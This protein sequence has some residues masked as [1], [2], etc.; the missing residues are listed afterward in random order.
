[1]I[2]RTRKFIWQGILL[3]HTADPDDYGLDFDNELDFHTRIKL[4]KDLGYNF[5][6]EEVEGHSINIVGRPLTMPGAHCLKLNAKYIGF[7]F[8]GNFSKISGPSDRRIL[9]AVRR[10]IIPLMIYYDLPVEKIEPHRKYYKTECPGKFFR[11]DKL[12]GE[13]KA[14]VNGL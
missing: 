3:H 10:V 11:W 12:I 13:I 7:A 8:E 5:I 4:W 6:N 14:G 9:D 1:M 2:Y